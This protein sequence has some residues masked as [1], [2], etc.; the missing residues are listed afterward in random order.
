[1]K[2]TLGASF[3]LNENSFI[4]AD[5]EFQNI[6][7]THYSFSNDS[8][9]LQASETNGYIKG[10]YTYSH[11]LRAGLQGAIKK[12]RLRAG[13]AYTNSPFKSGQNY[14]ASQYN[15]AIQTATFGV[16]LKF[17]VIYLD[18]AYVLTYSRDGISPGYIIPLDQINST[19]MTHSV[20][21]TLGFKIPSKGD[22][23][24]PAKQQRQRSSDQL[25]KYIDPGDKY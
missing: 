7:A 11:T 13:Y 17:K 6:G 12:L 3:Y 21:F 23:S 15:Q 24:S 20:L 10:T 19:Y 25:P 1:M 2:G 4:S 8:A 22:N 9:G 5:Y 14:T 16:G 18:L